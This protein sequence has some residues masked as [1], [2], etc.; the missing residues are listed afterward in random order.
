[1]PEGQLPQVQLRRNPPHRFRSPPVSAAEPSAD[2]AKRLSSSSSP[3][4]LRTNTRKARPL[5][6]PLPL[7]G[8]GHSAQAL[9]PLS[10]ASPPCTLGP[11]SGNAR[12]SNSSPV[13]GQH[14]L[15][16]L[17]CTLEPSTRAA[18]RLSG[19]SPPHGTGPSAGAAKRLSG[20]SPPRG[21]TP[22]VGSPKKLSS[23]SPSHGIIPSVVIAEQ[24]PS[25]STIRD[26][27]A[28]TRKDR[29]LSFSRS[30]CRLMSDAGEDIDSSS[31]LPTRGSRPSV[32]VVRKLPSSLSVSSTLSPISLGHNERSSGQ[33]NSLTP[34]EGLS[35]N[36]GESM[37]LSSLSPVCKLRPKKGRTKQVSF[38]LPLDGFDSAAEAA[39]QPNYS[40]QPIKMTPKMG[41]PVKIS[42]SA[43][44]G[45]VTHSMPNRQSTFSSIPRKMGP[46]LMEGRQLSASPSPTSMLYPKDAAQNNPPVSP[47]GLGHF[48]EGTRHAFSSI[49]PGLESR[50]EEVGRL[51]YS[52]VRHSM[53]PSLGT[54]SHLL[55]SSIRQRLGSY[56]GF[57]MSSHSSQNR[58]RPGVAEAE[59]SPSSLPQQDPG[60]ISAG[61]FR[62]RLSSSSQHGTG[63]CS[64]TDRHAFS[65]SIPC[66]L[67][68]TPGVTWRFCGSSPTHRLESSV[69]TK[70]R[71]SITS[72]SH[73]LWPTAREACYSPPFKLEPSAVA[74]QRLSSF[75]AQCG[76]KY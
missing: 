40:S 63:P 8:S 76:G 4:R 10:C 30:V 53:V 39:S 16:S 59:Q 70:D 29:S 12:L 49:E 46:T 51:S 61:V 33:I 18:R 5:S 67:G 28:F 44:C 71:V 25:S 37:K 42:S 22:K 36:N 20:S 34:S 27:G 7:R 15:S 13:P 38:S 64:S 52:S 9:R 32:G 2:A 1:M 72:L 19:L 17:P 3:C 54:S 65:S 23:S 58:M 31:S 41:I 73:E 66:R 56:G 74:A 68:S 60:V 45:S 75:S 47:H 55:T 43:Q 62:K 57:G 21:S 50:L 69:G 48:S 26:R 35:Q 6:T 24:F 11:S 14:T